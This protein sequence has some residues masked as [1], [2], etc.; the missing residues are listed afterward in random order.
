MSN[1]ISALPGCDISASDRTEPNEQ[2][3]QVLREC[4]EDAEAGSLQCIA[5]V[6]LR[7]NGNSDRAIVGVRTLEDGERLLGL[8]QML[9]FGML[10]A[11][12]LDE[13]EHG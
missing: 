2:V 8:L 1:N 7:A 12:A 3:I 5:L 11:H 13:A 4:L 9:S 10:N 6:G